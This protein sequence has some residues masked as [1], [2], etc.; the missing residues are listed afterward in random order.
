MVIVALRPHAAIVVQ[1]PRALSGVVEPAQQMHP[2]PGP[3]PAARP[4]PPPVL[5]SYSSEESDL[6]LADAEALANVS[7]PPS[8]LLLLLLP[9][10]GSW[11]SPCLTLLMPSIS[12]SVPWSH[13]ALLLQV[14]D[15]GACS[16]T[17]R[18]GHGGTIKIPAARH[19]CLNSQ[20]ELHM[21]Y[22]YEQ[23]LSG[24]FCHNASHGL[25]IQKSTRAAMLWQH[26]VVRVHYQEQCSWTRRSAPPCQARWNE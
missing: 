11:A 3:V 19:D 24:R 20:L 12:N 26:S 25:H 2:A 4:V 23:E 6:D 17:K 16:T 7:A 8:P 21:Q 14:Q 5:E 10:W 15:Y 18:S 1:E 22:M 13:V 9:I